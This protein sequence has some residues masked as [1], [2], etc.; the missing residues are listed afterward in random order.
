M[1]GFL[2]KMRSRLLKEQLSVSGVGHQLSSGQS[3]AFTSNPTPEMAAQ[4]FHRPGYPFFNHASILATTS[5]ATVSRR[6]LYSDVV[7]R[8]QC[9]YK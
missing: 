9:W 8:T 3:E 5:G 2:K 1:T 6:L 4:Y 7:Q